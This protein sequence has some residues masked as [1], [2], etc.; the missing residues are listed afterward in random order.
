MFWGLLRAQG[1]ATI[2][3]AILVAIAGSGEQVLIALW[4]G[5]ISLVAYSWAGFRLWLHPGNQRSD[6][7]M[8]PV[9]RAEVGKVVILLLLF[10]LTLSEWPATRSS[11]ALIL[12]AAFFFT[13]LAGWVWLARRLAGEQAETP[14]E[15]PRN[16]TPQGREDK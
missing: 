2:A 5:A 16:D 9:I 11:N 1:A 14:Q 12:F 10:W 15:T 13:Q 4:G 7:P 8:R 6:R 3:S